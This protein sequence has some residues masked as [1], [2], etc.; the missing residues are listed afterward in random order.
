MDAGAE[1]IDEEKFGGKEKMNLEKFIQSEDVRN[2]KVNTGEIELILNTLGL[3]SKDYDK[4]KIL[5]YVAA[6]K[7]ALFRCGLADI[8]KNFF[9]KENFPNWVSRELDIT[10]YPEISEL[11]SLIRSKVMNGNCH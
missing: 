5:P 10:D 11:I 4:L 2:Q 7:T 9:L 6:F 8:Q 1:K 3:A